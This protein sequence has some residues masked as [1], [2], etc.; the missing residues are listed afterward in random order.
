[1]LTI[2]EFGDSRHA[3]DDRGEW[4]GAIHADAIDRA[5]FVRIYGGL[6]TIYHVEDPPPNLFFHRHWGQIFTNPERL[7]QGTK[8]VLVEN[9]AEHYRDWLQAGPVEPIFGER[10][11][12]IA[13]A[14]EFRP[15]PDPD[16]AARSLAE[17]LTEECPHYHRAALLAKGC[18][19]SRTPQ[20]ICNFYRH[21]CADYDSKLRE[22]GDRLTL[23]IRYH[24]ELMDIVTFVKGKKAEIALAPKSGWNH[25]EIFEELAQ[26]DHDRIF[27][28]AL[29][30][31]NER[32]AEQAMLQHR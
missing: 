30:Q 17:R 2:Y 8:N 16:G 22:G 11:E 27:R 31:I 1:M 26:L 3:I 6:G 29:R 12:E 7:P 15:R 23:T 20:E 9:T 5:C 4:A 14:W 10:S 25:M 18:G 24:R 28:E 13:E 32:R 21:R 19:R